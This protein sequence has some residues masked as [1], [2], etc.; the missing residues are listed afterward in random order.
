MNV[1]YQN[2]NE[3]MNEA[4]LGETSEQNGGMTK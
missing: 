4:L 1:P 3:V 2:I